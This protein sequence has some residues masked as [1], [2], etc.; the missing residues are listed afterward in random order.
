MSG[1]KA[2]VLA[3]QLL[4]DAADFFDSVAEQNPG[5][6]DEMGKAAQAYRMMADRLDAG[7]REGLN[8]GSAETPQRSLEALAARLLDDAADFFETVAAQNPE[9]AQEMTDNAEVYRALGEMIA[10]DPEARLPTDA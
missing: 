2:T 9:F 4:R 7:D 1:V 6:S 10:E 8:V 5:L 3:S